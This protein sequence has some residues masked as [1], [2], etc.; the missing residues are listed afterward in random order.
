MNIRNV[1]TF[2]GTLLSGYSR[3]IKKEKNL[4][5]RLSKPYVNSIEAKKKKLVVFIPASRT[6]GKQNFRF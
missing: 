4:H 5:N 3:I 2:R 1:S 6:G